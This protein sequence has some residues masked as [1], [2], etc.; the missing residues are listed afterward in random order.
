MKWMAYHLETTRFVLLPETQEDL[1]L[2]KQSFATESEY[3]TK[4]MIEHAWFMQ[5]IMDWEWKEIQWPLTSRVLVILGQQDSSAVWTVPKDLLNVWTSNSNIASWHLRAHAWAVIMT[6]PSLPTACS[7][8]K[9][10]L[11]CIVKLAVYPC[12]ST[13]LQV[14][15]LTSLR[16]YQLESTG[17]KW[18]HGAVETSEYMPRY[19]Q[20]S[21]PWLVDR[22]W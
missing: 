9:Q 8:S 10:F 18:C 14:P 5:W 6:T 16:T 4:M 15:V 12:I 11:S 7:I 3:I 22:F 13:H 21:D 17:S 1:Q 19:L 20:Y 2:K